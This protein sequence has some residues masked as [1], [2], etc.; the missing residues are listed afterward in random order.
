MKRKGRI[1]FIAF[2]ALIACFTLGFALTACNND[3]LTSLII[4]GD[5][6]AA[7][8]FDRDTL[9]ALAGGDYSSLENVRGF[10]AELSGSKKKSDGIKQVVEGKIYRVNEFGLVYSSVRQYYDEE[11]VQ[12]I[13]SY[14]FFEKSGDT[15]YKTTY[16][17]SKNK[18]PGQL[19]NIQN[20]LSTGVEKTEFRFVDSVFD[21]VKNDLNDCLIEDLDFVNGKF[22]SEGYPC[23][24]DFGD[25]KLTLTLKSEGGLLDEQ[26][27]VIS[28]INST[29]FEVP[30]EIRAIDKSGALAAKTVKFENCRYNLS[31]DGRSYGVNYYFDTE[32]TAAGQK[33][34]VSLLS[35]I[36]GLPITTMG[37]GCFQ[38]KTGLTAITIPASVTEIGINAFKGCTALKNVTFAGKKLE[39]IGDEAFKD[40][41]ELSEINIS[42]SVKQIGRNAFSGSGI[43]EKSADNSVV[44]VGNF[45]VGFKGNL[46]DVTLRDGTK[47]ISGA[48]FEGCV[49]LTVITIPDSVTEIGVFA[50]SGC[51]SL[52]GFNI[53]DSV[54]SI[55][56]SAFKDCSSLVSVTIPDNVTSIGY[57]AFSGCSGLTSIIVSDNNQ[58]FASQD[59]I[60]YNK[61]KTRFI[62]VP[63]NLSGAIIIPNSVTSIGSSA[64]WGCTG[65]TFVTIPDSVTSIG[66]YAFYNCSGLTS[67]TIPNNVTS[68]GD[69]AFYK[70][71]ELT[72][73]T[74]PKSVTSI[75]DSAFSGCTAL[76]S[77]TIPGSVQQI[78][79]WAFYGCSRNISIKCQAAEKPAGWDNDWHYN[80]PPENIVWGYTGE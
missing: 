67:V 20:T 41:A 34:S 73:V 53:P 42:D 74:I 16:A 75:G 14:V 66:N 2:L 62:H 18:I 72:S 11:L 23:T 80:L 61:A 79:Y 52:A 6:G 28:N 76:T 50:F 22:T 33:F 25:S 69:S 4:S 12:E 32:E 43:I 40:C 55:G 19:E 37:Y 10:T 8:A 24:V 71:I 26:K 36:N 70:C 45:V 64:F 30:A 58:A 15:Y 48:A 29:Q 54:T 47:G 51:S 3:T 56:D 38:N 5:Q 35:E 7:F 63:K 27:V 46:T 57:S 31:A 77:I 1:I 44:Y 39:T 59:G 13:N 21:M 78:G 17:V 68:I 65:L 49:G 9:I 60:L